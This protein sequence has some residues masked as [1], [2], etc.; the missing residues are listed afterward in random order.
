M[1]KR[2]DTAGVIRYPPILSCVHYTRK[3]RRDCKNALVRQHRK[4]P[5]SDSIFV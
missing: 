1:G 2:G 4:L 5:R 3:I